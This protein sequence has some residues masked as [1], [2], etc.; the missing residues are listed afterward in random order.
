[1]H[2]FPADRL[3]G[4]VAI[5]A[6]VGLGLATWLIQFNPNQ[7]TLSARFFPGL[8]AVLLVGLGAL[9]VLRPGP[10]RLGEVAGI[11]LDR[12]V[13]LFAAAV[14]LYFLTFRHLD[15]RVGTWLFMLG[16][17]VLLGARRPLELALVPLLTALLVWLTFRYGFTV[18]L[19]TWG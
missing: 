2:P 3:L 19:P 16:S 9:L 10:D 1:M 17:M 14:L 8:L 4:A 13:L 18:L 12:R 11:L 15:F 5:L 7:L 6:G